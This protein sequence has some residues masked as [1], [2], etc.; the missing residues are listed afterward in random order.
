[1]DVS[2]LELK[3]DEVFPGE[4]YKIPT[5]LSTLRSYL[6]DHK[7]LDEEGIFRVAGDEI[8]TGLASLM[9]C[10]VFFG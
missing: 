1:V 4:P 5:V 6:V 8:E 9:L 7:G 2:E 10:I 3:D